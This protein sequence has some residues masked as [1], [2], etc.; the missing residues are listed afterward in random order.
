MGELDPEELV[1]KFN[2]LNTYKLS[3]IELQIMEDMTGDQGALNHTNAK[4][5]ETF[6]RTA[7]TIERYMSRI[8]RKLEVTNRTSAALIYTAVRKK[9]LII[10]L[11]DLEAY[12]E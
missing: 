2:L 12:D 6:H 5:A 8:L 11:A 7:K 4:L 10:P 1:G 9:R 3:P